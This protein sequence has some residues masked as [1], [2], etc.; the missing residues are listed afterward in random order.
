MNER[1]T[2]FHG[3]AEAISRRIPEWSEAKARHRWGVT[4]GPA[5]GAAA[6]LPERPED[7]HRVAQERFLAAGRKLVPEEEAK[8]RKDPF[9]MWDEI[10]ANG[11][12]QRF[13]KG[14]DVFLHKFHGL[15][16]VAPAQN[17]FMCRLRMPGGILGTHQF[18]GLAEL[19][20]RYGGGY[21]DVTTR[22]NL[23]IREIA[24]ASAP[25]VLS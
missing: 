14:T 12:A 2:G 22:A 16:Y 7:I 15:F 19:A 18:R 25:A 24:A 20:D 9:A 6:G 10:V 5:A 23:Q 13:P 21:A 17:S 4:V 8:R 11:A 3:R 1:R